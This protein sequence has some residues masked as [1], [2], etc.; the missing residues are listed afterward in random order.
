MKKISKWGCRILAVVMAVVMVGV[1]PVH[2]A[3][4]DGP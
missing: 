4:P 3:E 1:I 2:A